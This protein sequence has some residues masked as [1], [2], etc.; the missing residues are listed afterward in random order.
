MSRIRNAGGFIGTNFR[1]NGVLAISRA[2]GDHILKDR[3]VV[4]AEPHCV[5]VLLLPQSHKNSTDGDYLLL[6]ACDGVWDVVSDKEAVDFVLDFIRNHKSL[7]EYRFGGAGTQGQE[8]VGSGMSD[9]DIDGEP[10]WSKC[11]GASEAGASDSD[12]E[13]DW[14][15]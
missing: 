10:R 8:A 9:T 12:E 7:P 3:N 2:L 14:N 5:T 4:S 15:R 13:V 6:L 1:V 11:A